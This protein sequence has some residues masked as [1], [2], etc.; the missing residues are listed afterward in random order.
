MR[1]SHLF[2]IFSIFIF[3]LTTGCDKLPF[4]EDYFPS[5]EKD[6]V[7]GEPA[8]K[9]LPV[10]AKKVVS[11]VKPKAKNVLASVG[12]WTITVDEF[13]E[14]TKA[15]KE[16]MPEY[17]ENDLETKKLVL[18]ELVRQQLLVDEALKRG[19]DKKE[20]VAAALD[21]FTKTLL[22]RELAV[23]IAESITVSDQ[24]AK[25]FYDENQELFKE[26]DQWRIREILV[27]NE[28]RAK[29]LAVALLQGADFAQVAREN[30]IAQTASKGGDVGFVSE[31]EDPKVQNTVFTLEQGSASNVF[32]G[33]K[34]YYI[35][36]LEEK[37]Q[38]VLQSFDDVK[39]E[40]KQGLVA[41]NQ[42]QA[43]IDYVENLRS[44]AN[45]EINE[46]LLK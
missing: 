2:I 4:L 14:K 10:L 11:S 33:D 28:G 34:G 3:A 12:D 41:M 18:E 20:N 42:Q 22:V 27:D 5:S 6:S 21:E 9:E 31:F 16:V 38:G 29:E 19:I 39:E 44:N 24:E 46:D 45:I 13:N 35:V 30:S 40:L 17:D 32:K 8:K 43:I 15:L 23:E 25:V 1:K 26:P 36:K 37:K 7:Q